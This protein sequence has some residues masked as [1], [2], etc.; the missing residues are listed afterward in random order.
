MPCPPTV[1][2]DVLGFEPIQSVIGDDKMIGRIMLA[3]RKLSK[4]NHACGTTSINRTSLPRDGV[5]DNEKLTLSTRDGVNEKQIAEKHFS[6][7]C[8]TCCYSSHKLQTDFPAGCFHAIHGRPLPQP[9]ALIV[10]IPEPQH[11]HMFSPN[12]PNFISFLCSSFKSACAN[13]SP[14]RPDPT[15]TSYFLA[16]AM[17]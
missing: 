10:E 9:H 3:K 5:T 13:I 14:T 16:L 4:Q 2:C 11:L 1:A 8:R 7:I 6:L 17:A 12:Y 15:Y